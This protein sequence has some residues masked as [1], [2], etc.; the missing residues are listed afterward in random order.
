MQLR[1]RK[2]RK[3]GGLLIYTHAYTYLVCKRAISACRGRVHSTARIPIG[4]DCQVLQL[5][6]DRRERA[7]ALIQLYTLAACW[8]VEA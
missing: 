6:L 4:R 2:K 7:G 1:V 3:K 8:N 5:Y